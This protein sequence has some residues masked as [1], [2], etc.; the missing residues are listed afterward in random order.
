VQLP[1]TS[2]SGWARPV[3]V[4]RRG[5][6]TAPVARASLAPTVLWSSLLRSA[7]VLA[8]DALRGIEEETMSADDA[9]PAAAMGPDA[10]A[11]ATGANAAAP[12]ERAALDVAHGIGRVLA[13][14][15]DDV[16][17]ETVDLIDAA[18]ARRGIATELVDAPRFDF[19]PERGLCPGDMVYRPAISMHAT[20]V[21][22]H[23]WTPQIASFDLDP[24]GPLFANINAMTT[25]ARAGLP[26]PRTYW[27]A[28]GN[29]ALIQTYVEALGGFPIVVK[30]LGYSRG[31]GTIRADSL[32]SL[33][34]IVDYALVQGTKPL[35]TSYVEDAVHWRVVVVGYA[36]VA[37]YRN[38]L[39]E[40]DF[41]TSGSDDLDDYRAPP[42]EGAEALAVA[43]CR[44]LRHAH[45]GVDLLEHP[46]GRLYLLEANYPCYYATAQL[47]AGVDVAGAMVDW[48][49]RRAI[50]LAPPAGVR[51]ARL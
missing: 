47:E 9:T 11:S 50:A 23:L 3:G 24:D 21:E 17:S 15:D 34:S 27:L 16:P 38:V 40:G 29:R 35:L 14:I 46:S 31:V 20:R 37:S 25:F 36:A 19:S 22:Q 28:S 43:A 12:A 2:G 30:A 51:A 5:A 6:L 41:R 18:A 49:L 45:G 1:A 8:T 32:A 4:G 10:A 48:L 26:V 39:D 44:A 7:R 42:P 13:I 33:Y